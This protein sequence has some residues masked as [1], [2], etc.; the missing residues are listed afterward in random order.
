MALILAVATASLLALL[1]AGLGQ[2]WPFYRSRRD[3]AVDRQ[4]L[5]HGKDGLVVVNFQKDGN[6]DQVKADSSYTREIM[7]L[8]AEV[9]H[10]P[11]HVGKAVALQEQVDFDRVALVYFPG[12]QYLIDMVQSTYYTKIFE[13]KQ[14]GDNL[15]TP[16]VPI[17]QHL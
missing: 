6:A 4:P 1:L 3:N 9:G 10:G 5:F 7:S 17:L 15:S 12:F 14:L 16:T 8:M 11:L 2:E 13:N